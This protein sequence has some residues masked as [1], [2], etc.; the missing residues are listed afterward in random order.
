VALSGGT[1]SFTVRVTN[2]AGASAFALLTIIVNAL[3]DPGFEEATTSTCLYNPSG[4]SWTFS[5][6]SASGSDSGVATGSWRHQRPA[7]PFLGL[8]V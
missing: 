4:G 2:A 7:L 6:A 8:L 5:G 1:N 3:L